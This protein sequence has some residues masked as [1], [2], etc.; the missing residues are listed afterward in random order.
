MGIRKPFVAA[1]NALLRPLGAELV[2]RQ[3]EK[4]WDR[5]FQEWIAEARTSGRDPN[6][7]GDVVWANDPLRQALIEHYFPHIDRDSV[8]LELG[9]GTGRATRHIIGRCREMILVD[10]SKLVCDWLRSYL[11][12]KGAFKIHNIDGPLLPMV[13]TESVDMAFANGVFEHIEIYSMFRFLEEFQ[14]VLKPQGVCAFNFDNLASEEGRAWF[15]RWRPEPGGHSPFCFYHPDV[16]RR[17]AE[18]I[19][20][21]ALRVTTG[22]SRLAYIELRKPASCSRDVIAAVRDIQRGDGNCDEGEMV[23]HSESRRP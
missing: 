4:P 22:P 20:F 10:Y 18:E 9:P 12:G 8:V 3:D 16:V 7:V 23:R 17:L 13:D 11:A 19:G 21:E 2:R 5:D 14:R 1:V 15:R 6:D